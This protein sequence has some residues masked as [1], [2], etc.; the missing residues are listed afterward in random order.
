MR[1]VVW[2]R[3]GH[4]AI[5]ARPDL[6]PGPGEVAMRVRAASFSSADWRVG[7]ATFPRGFDLPAH[8]ALGLRGP[9][10]AVLGTDAAGVVEAVGKGVTDWRP[11]DAAVAITGV[12]FGGHAERVVLPATQLAP[13]PQRLSFEEAAAIPFGAVTALHFLDRIAGLR[14][15]ERLLVVGASGAVG[16]A[17]VQIACHRGARVAAV[18]SSANAELVSSLGAGRVFDYAREDALVEDTWD[19]IL[20]AA[21]T[22][23]MSDARRALARG[24]RLLLVLSDLGATLRSPLLRGR[25]RRA[26]AGPAPD[27][28]EDLREAM[29][30]ADAG[31]LRPVIDS[32]HS[33]EEYALAL[34]RVASGR[35]RGAVILRMGTT[36]AS[37]IAA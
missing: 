20:D 28:P 4:F 36:S 29:R 5:A 31:A 9:R 24:G 27:R 3:Y 7:T 15:G 1:A 37:G 10:R 23:A 33:M 8:V 16:S 12:R 6:E 17:A 22:V 18:C 35:K 26:H 11:G 32:V 25:G 34:A 21:G 14:A 2:G 13:I 19:V 30:L